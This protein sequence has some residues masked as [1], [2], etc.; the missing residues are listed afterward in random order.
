MAL[1]KRKWPTR[2]TNKLGN[3]KVESLC[4]YGFSHRSKLERAVCDLI[5]W[6]EKAGVTKHLAHEDTQYLTEARYRYI[7]DFKVQNMAT[8]EIY[9]V[10]AKGYADA[11]WPTTKKLWRFYGPGRLKIYGGT[12]TNIKM[13]EEI[14][15]K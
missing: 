12:Y 1:V 14:R 9:W 6:E 10:E 2:K 15:P 4:S 11:R 8:S 7:P 3:E 13:I 5:A